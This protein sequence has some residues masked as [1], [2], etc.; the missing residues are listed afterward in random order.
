MQRI[1]LISA[2]LSL[3]LS[4]S[5][6]ATLTACR[7]AG[8][9]AGTDPEGGNTLVTA[10]PN[11]ADPAIGT[12]AGNPQETAS[13]ETA[14]SV[15]PA[16]APTEGAYIATDETVIRLGDTHVEIAGEGA[17]AEGGTVTV[18]RAGTYLIS[19]TRTGGQI[20]VDTAD[21][22]KVTL[23]LNGASLSF[24]EGPAILVKSAP[25]K[26]VIATVAGSV[27]I[28]ADGG[29]YVVPD[30]E[31]VAGGLYPNACLYACDDL[32]LDGAG[33]LQITGHADKGINTKD[34]LK[35]KGGTV[36][37]T[38]AGVGIRANDSF[39]MS[40]GTVTIHSGGDGIK[41]ANI[42]TEGKGTLTLAGGSLY[43]T[44]KGDGLS[45][46]TDLSV[47]GGTAV[48]TTTDEDGAVLPESSGNA[49]G[50][51]HSGGF[52]GGMF[53]GGGRPGMPGESTSDKAAISAKGLKAAGNLTVNSG[54]LTVVA[55][56]DGLHANGNLTVTGGTLH[57]RA[58][59]DGLHA[60][61]ELVISGGVTEVAQSYEGLEA[62][63]ITVA[64]GTNRI[65][66][67]DDGANATSGEGGGM[68]GPG[69]FPG[70][71]RPGMPGSSQGSVEFSEDQPCL[72]FAGGYT[73][74]DTGGDGVDSNGWIKMTGG[75]VLVFGPT[76][77]GNGPIDT[78]DGGYSMTVSGGTFL[79][80][81]S[82]GMAETAENGGQA[83]IAAYWN[84][85]GLTAGDTVGIADADGKV[86]AVFELPKAIASIVFSSP[87]I[88]TGKTYSVISGGTFTDE[89]VDG[90]IEATTY[91]G[92]EA[93]GEI[94]AY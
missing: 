72:T 12:S 60:E 29:D 18:T 59:D 1:R 58:A 49:T 65:T 23:L 33:T 38:A 63:H 6:L 61:K 55:Q 36:T 77:N 64:G 51:S 53:G 82:S 43:I 52:G 86:I 35:I 81:G 17:A 27:N 89:A 21:A 54:K 73:V 19:G 50:G 75:T 8:D 32:E 5:S 80:V 4:L 46:A 74:F 9:G 25:K 15:T 62:L 94:E 31:Q 41:T 57:I 24:A 88:E 92:F 83:V 67:S 66:A 71:G 91:T 11:G 48:I 34:D 2:V 30:E 84:R 90:V 14:P 22:G 37:V 85:T 70:G 40:G 56:D 28:L 47:T 20:I 3:L 93:M 13:P 69:G 87:V 16:E 7:S 78:G 10:D 39:E 45:A 79:A 76:D 44:A 68:G 26:V 42:E